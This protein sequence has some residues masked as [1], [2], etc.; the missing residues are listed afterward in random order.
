MAS[1]GHWPWPVACE[2][3]HHAWK[4]E[5]FNN[6]LED[7]KLIASKAP[8]QIAVED[9]FFFMYDLVGK[10]AEALIG[11]AETL[12]EE[13]S[14]DGKFHSLRIRIDRH[15]QGVT[16][17]IFPTSEHNPLAG[18]SQIELVKGIGLAHKYMSKA[19]E[20]VVLASFADR[21]SRF[22]MFGYTKE[23]WK[24][25]PEM[26]QLI[27]IGFKPGIPALTDGTRSSRNR[28]CICGSGRKFKRCCGK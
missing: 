5:S 19:D 23:P 9:L 24:P 12:K 16:L 4:T 6:L 14:L 7:I 8:K 17:A 2:T 22:D 28:S 11:S 18:L 3:L 20:W 1:R 13:A 21:P 26:D 15:E 10:G 25:D 27:E